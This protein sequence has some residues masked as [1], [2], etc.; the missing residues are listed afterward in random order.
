MTRKVRWL[1]ALMAEYLGWQFFPAWM[2]LHLTR[3]TPKP[4]EDDELAS[5]H[6]EA[7]RCLINLLYLYPGRD[8]ITEDYPGL[9]RRDK[10]PV[11]TKIVAPTHGAFRGSKHPG[12]FHRET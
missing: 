2:N 9:G 12:Q 3:E 7:L 6:N 10:T 8:H 1:P 4:Q 11:L 5:Y